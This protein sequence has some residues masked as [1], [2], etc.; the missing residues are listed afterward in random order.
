MREHEAAD[1]KPPP[2]ATSR[3][4]ASATA[5]D[6]Q[7][8]ARSIVELVT[9]ILVGRRDATGE[10]RENPRDRGKPLAGKSTL[11]RLELT[12]PGA[13]ADSRYKKIV[14]NHRE[15]RRNVFGSTSNRRS[16]GIKVVLVSPTSIHCTMSGR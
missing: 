11:N 2:C 5:N 13:S 12:P 10:N 8:R 15:I 9:P 7:L 14:A 4:R 3:A 1:E 16:L 6:D